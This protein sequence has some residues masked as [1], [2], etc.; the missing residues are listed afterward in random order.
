MPRGRWRRS[1]SLLWGCGLIVLLAVTA[2]AAPLL[3]PYPPDEQLDPAAASYRT[4]GTELAAVHRNDGSWR[5]ADRGPRPP[6][7]L[8]IERLGAAETLP[9]SEVLNLTPGGV[10]DRRLY[11]L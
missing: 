6:P 7:G 2:L 4:P 10:A 3:A 8:E 9:A 1:P 11:L 5:L